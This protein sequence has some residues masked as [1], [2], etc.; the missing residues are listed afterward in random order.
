MARPEPGADMR[1]REFIALI[2]GATVGW[3]L[4]AHT[5]QP[6]TSVIGYL[7]SRSPEAVADRLRGLR[8]GLKETGY[9]EGENVAIAYLWAEDRIDRLPAL[10]ADLVRR[11]VAAIVAAGPPST[12][13]AKAATTTIPIVF[14]VGNDP[15][16]LGLATSLSRPGG[17]MTGINLFNSELG[18]K[19]LELLRDLLPGAARI[20]VLVNPADRTLTETQLK[21][22]NAAARAMGLQIQVHNA[23]TSA[24]INA[25]FEAIGRERPDAVFVAVTPFFNGRRVQLAQLAAFHR[26]P[27]IYALRDYAEAGGLMSYGSDIIDGYRQVGLYVG[28]ILLAPWPWL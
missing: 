25:A 6:T 9:I 17:N 20:A 19:R 24:E 10:A 27:A 16:Q 28:R 2:G 13:A 5:Q 18:A 7:D 26:L 1:R 8:Q 12:F 23:D 11:P 14:L 15:V 3:P 4:V 21:E 22:L